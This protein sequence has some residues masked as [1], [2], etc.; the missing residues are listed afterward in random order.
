MHSFF[1][2]VCVC[3]CHTLYLR[4]S[5]T[6]SFQAGD[7]DTCIASPSTKLAI[8]GEDISSGR[9]TDVPATRT[10]PH[11]VTLLFPF[12]LPWWLS[13]IPSP[14]TGFLRHCSCCRRF[15]LS[16]FEKHLFNTQ[17]L[18][19]LLPFRS[20]AIFDLGT[21]LTENQCQSV[22]RS[23][24][25]RVIPVTGALSSPRLPF[26]GL[27]GLLRTLDSLNRLLVHPCIPKTK[28]PPAASPPSHITPL[29]LYPLPTA[30]SSHVTIQDA[31]AQTTSPWISVLDTHFTAPMFHQSQ[32][33]TSRPDTHSRHAQTDINAIVLYPAFAGIPA[34][35]HTE[36]STSSNTTANIPNTTS[37]NLTAAANKQ[38][39]ERWQYVNLIP[40]P[41]VTTPAQ[42][43]LTQDFPSPIGGTPRHRHSKTPPRSTTPT[44]TR[45]P[46]PPTSCFST[47]TSF[48]PTT[49]RMAI[50]LSSPTTT[51]APNTTGSRIHNTTHEHRSDSHPV[52]CPTIGLL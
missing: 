2:A 1:G 45:Q 26:N 12:F 21:E 39:H 7:G 3:V 15:R 52:D 32:Q 41:T 37:P 30:S 25:P 35:P 46:D 22:C 34:T 17:L 29:R 33:T 36:Q 14:Q 6:H 8:H 5:S 19:L 48:G 47:S 10:F 42:P 9:G 27:S 43:E 16:V 44:R 40:T 31:T 28:K 51:A 23:A 4:V 11:A 50:L 38:P 13:M 24:V 49:T 18:G 20:I